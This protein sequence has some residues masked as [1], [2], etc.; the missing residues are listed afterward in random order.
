[1][2][3][4]RIVCLL[5]SCALLCA[6]AAP[7]PQEEPSADLEAGVEAEEKDLQG[8]ASLGYGYY[9][10]PY[11]SYYGHGHGHGGYWPHYS[12]SYYG[13]GYPYYGGYYGLHSHHGH[14]GHY[15]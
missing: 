8:A 13:L 4:L 15:F 11:Y 2:L 14:Y 7:R 3:S 1:M 10:S 12:G 5:L 9:T 6:E